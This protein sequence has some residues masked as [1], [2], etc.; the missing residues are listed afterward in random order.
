M[1][2]SKVTHPPAAHAVDKERVLTLSFLVVKADLTVA[3]T[4]NSGGVWL[5]IVTDTIIDEF[6]HVVLHFSHELIR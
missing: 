4:H 1:P 2:T 3:D 5:G 6:V